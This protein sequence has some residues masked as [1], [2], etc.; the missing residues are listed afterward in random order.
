MQALKNVP[1]SLLALC[2]IIKQI[3]K[4]NVISCRDHYDSLSSQYHI[5]SKLRHIYNARLHAVAANRG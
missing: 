2:Q 5:D 4:F 1:F 3:Y